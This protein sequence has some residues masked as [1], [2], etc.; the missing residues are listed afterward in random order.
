MKL[1]VVASL[2][3]HV[4]GLLAIPTE[5]RGDAAKQATAGADPRPVAVNVPACKC[6][7]EIGANDC[8]HAAETP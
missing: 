5:G 8:A 3:I 1:A 7:L 2:V 4:A 6:D